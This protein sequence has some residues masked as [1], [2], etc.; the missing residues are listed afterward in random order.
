MKKLQEE[1]EEVNYNLENL[2]EY[3]IK[4]YQSLLDKYGKGR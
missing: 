4:Y 1:L 3:A 2:V